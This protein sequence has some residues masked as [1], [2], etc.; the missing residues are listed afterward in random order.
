MPF[1]SWKV[2][3]VYLAELAKH[4]QSWGFYAGNSALGPKKLHNG[5]WAWLGTIQRGCVR[6]ALHRAPYLPSLVPGK[7]PCGL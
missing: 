7:W 2:H 4:L 6:F 3:F 5:N 1:Y